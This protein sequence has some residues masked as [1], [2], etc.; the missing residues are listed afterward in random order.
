MA[1]EHEAQIVRLKAGQADADAMGRLMESV[2]VSA[3]KVQPSTL[4]HNS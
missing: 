4:N 3:E 1:E 2:A